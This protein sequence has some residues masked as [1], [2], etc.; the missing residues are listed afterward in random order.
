MWARRDGAMRQAG[1]TRAATV[2][3]AFEAALAYARERTSFGKAIVDH[4]ALNF[5]LADMA[6]ALEAARQNG[7]SRYLYTSSACVY[8]EFKQTDVVLVVGANDVVSFLLPLL[9]Q[10]F[11][12][13]YGAE[14][15]GIA[16]PVNSTTSRSSRY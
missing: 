2:E 8:P 3:E 4:Q 13:L 14:A 7:V 15:A 11:L 6:T 1:V 9:P 5:R 12:T 16:N 10:S